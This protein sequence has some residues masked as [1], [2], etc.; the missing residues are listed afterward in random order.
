MI[1]QGKTTTGFPLLLETH[2]CCRKMNEFLHNDDFE[3]YLQKKAGQHRMYPDDKVWRNISKQVQGDKQWPG[4]SAIS[5]IVVAALITGTLI[6][7]PRPDILNSNYHFTLQSPGIGTNPLNKSI[8]QT[9]KTTAVIDEH[10]AVEKITSKTLL[11]ISEKMNAENNIYS[12][13]ENETNN[14]TASNTIFVATQEN[15]VENKNTVTIADKANVT[16]TKSPFTVSLSYDALQFKFR[17]LF[18]KFPIGKN[19]NLMNQLP[20]YMIAR[21]NDQHIELPAE[22]KTASN[23]QKSALDKLK[24]KSSHF[25]FRFYVTPSV[26]YRIL[27]QKGTVLSNPK[28]TIGVSAPIEA[29]YNID[30]NQAINQRPAAGYETG[31]GL[32]YNLGKN[33]AV[34]AGI[35][36]NISQYN[37]DAYL[38]KSEEPA[39]V[40]LEENGV[41]STYTSYSNVRSISGSSAVTFKTRYYQASI[42]IG[43]DVKAWTKGKLTWGIAATVQPT[44]TFD[45]LP[46]IISSN[47]KNYTDGSRFIR[48]WN[49]NTSV[50]T[51]FGYTTG[52]YRW[53]IGPQFRYQWLPSLENKYPTKE[54]LFNYG[55]KLGVIKYLRQ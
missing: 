46:L 55:L 49:I 41:T 51:Y 53:Q 32:G 15:I 39:A 28:N 24:N 33:V 9:A 30:A 27:Q 11:A 45:K 37:V 43:V 47:F 48:N 38:Y 18:D 21:R 42:P 3:Q 12:V 4:L 22:Q 50:E 54:Y 14:L 23:T 8:Q 40:T 29:N 35:Q 2:N 44:Y 7:K 1:N 17:N 52:L 10:F 36:F 25:D 5:F 20:D 16:A 31:L 13:A 6:I 19:L 34:T 26:S